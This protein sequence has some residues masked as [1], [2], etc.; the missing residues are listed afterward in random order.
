MTK[1]KLFLY[2]YIIIVIL[3]SFFILSYFFVFYPIKYK[4]EIK[5]SA[6][7]FNLNPALVASVIYT[8][9]KFNPTAHSKAGAIGLMQLMPSTAQE[10]S[11]KLN[12]SNFSTHNLLSPQF[13]IRLGCFYLSQLLHQFNNLDTALCAYNAGP[14]KVKTWL[15]NPEYSKDQKTLFLIPYKETQNY[16]AK[17]KQKIKIY[18]NY[19]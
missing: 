8:E 19:F 13:N 12:I 5:N 16:L 6:Q 4:E 15:Q 1:T 11:T 10:I 18:T 3:I 7:E 17:I 9:S 14:N 2:S